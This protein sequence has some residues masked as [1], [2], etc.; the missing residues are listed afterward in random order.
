MA[1]GTLRMRA[2]VWAS[3]VLPHPVGPEQQNVA[4]L[5]LHVVGT[6]AGVDTLIVIV[7]GHRQ[8]FFGRLL[9]DYVLVQDFLNLLR[10]G[11]VAEF[12]INFIVHL[13]FNDLVAQLDALVANVNARSGDQLLD[14]V[15]PLTAKGT[16]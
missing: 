9:A 8:G 2:N 6:D 15:L 12:D 7:H 1:N 3:S 4:L 5:Q 10:S 16:F 13:F 14:L 11:Y